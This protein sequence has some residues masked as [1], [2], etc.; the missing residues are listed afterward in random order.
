MKENLRFILA[1]L[2][3]I[4]LFAIITML[5]ILSFPGQFAHM[6]R[7]HSIDLVI[8]IFLTLLVGIWLFFGQ[9]SLV[10]LWKLLGFAQK[11]EF[12]TEHS[13]RWL[14][15]LYRAC[16][17]AVAMPILLFLLLAPRA[18]DPGVL[19]ML[20]AVTLFLLTLTIFLSILKDQIR[21]K[22]STSLS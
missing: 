7:V 17:G 4:A 8:E 21:S 22:V 11:D 16:Q 3:L 9:A 2:A 6:R 19:V 12:F 5:Q 20:T 18:D 15:R 1:K 13:S 10:V 14:T